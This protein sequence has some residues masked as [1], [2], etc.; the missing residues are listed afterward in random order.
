MHQLTGNE[1]KIWK[2]HNPL[3]SKQDRIPRSNTD[4]AYGRYKFIRFYKIARYLICCSD[5]RGITNELF[6]DINT[7]V[8]DTYGRQ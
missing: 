5:Q 4:K 2:T 1:K 3:R 6:M 7:I 8:Y